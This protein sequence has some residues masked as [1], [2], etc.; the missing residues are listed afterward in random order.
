MFVRL[1]FDSLK[2]DPELPGP[3]LVY[4][5]ISVFSRTQQRLDSERKEG[6]V[7]EG[8]REGRT[9]SPGEAT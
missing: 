8:G 9:E 6:R 1:F 4:K 3:D 7:R 2:H 5:L